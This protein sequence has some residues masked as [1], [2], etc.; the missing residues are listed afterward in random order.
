MRLARLLRT[1]K[2]AILQ[3]PPAAV[4]FMVKGCPDQLVALHAL[5]LLPAA[6]TLN[7]NFVAAAV[8]LQSGLY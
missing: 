7:I 2:P 1:C 3:Q 8:G 6:S 5:W 4:N